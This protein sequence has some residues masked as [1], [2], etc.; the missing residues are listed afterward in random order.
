MTL[1]FRVLLLCLAVGFAAPAMAQTAAPGTTPA[2]AEP[3]KQCMTARK[4]EDKEQRSLTSAI[5]SIAKD[6]K[7]RESCSSKSMC[8]RYD[9]AISAMEKR[10]A[11]HETRLTRF[12]EEVDNDCKPK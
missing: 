10:K 12:K 9:A 6:T 4:K 8:A 5:D 2:V 1:Y 11:R 3:S 7:A